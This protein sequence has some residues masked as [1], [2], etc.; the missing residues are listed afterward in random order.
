MSQPLTADDVATQ[1]QNWNA[2]PVLDMRSWT[3]GNAQE[4]KQ[5]AQRVIE[6]CKAAGFFYVSG[7][8]V[9]P[10]ALR[11]DK[12]NSLGRTVKDSKSFRKQ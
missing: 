12:P 1:G 4:K 5:F 10:Q 2:L 7:H 3:E 9:T 11:E 8:S 6:T